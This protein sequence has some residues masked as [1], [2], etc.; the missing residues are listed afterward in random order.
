MARNAEVIDLLACF[1]ASREFLRNV[2]IL[3]GNLSVEYV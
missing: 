3:L 1:I 2:T